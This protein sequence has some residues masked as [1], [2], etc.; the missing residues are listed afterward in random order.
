[1]GPRG[2]WFDS[3]LMRR[4]LKSGALSTLGE[5]CRRWGG[6]P[7]CWGMVGRGSVA[8]HGVYVA[9]DSKANI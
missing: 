2:S 1:M 5:F 8:E 7:G 3:S 6:T 4:Q 9:V